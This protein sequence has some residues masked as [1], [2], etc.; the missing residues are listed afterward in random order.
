[1]RVLDP[2]AD[3]THSYTE[4]QTIA[5]RWRTLTKRYI[6]H[7]EPLQG[8]SIMGSLARILMATRSFSDF[9]EAMEFVGSSAGVDVEAIIEAT[10]VG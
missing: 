8:G 2:K 7:Q 10:P 6:A 3:H 5:S 4:G 1:M 9:S